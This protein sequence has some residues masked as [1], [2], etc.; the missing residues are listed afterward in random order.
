MD[1]AWCRDDMSPLHRLLLRNRADMRRIPLVAATGLLAAVSVITLVACS[2]P[3]FEN[4]DSGS[5]G[6]EAPWSRE[7]PPAPAR[8]LDGPLERFNAKYAA[9]EGVEGTGQ[10]MTSTGE[11]AITVYVSG[12]GDA[13]RIPDSF[14]GHPVLVRT[15]P[16]GFHATHSPAGED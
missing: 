10:G 6:S 15:V 1:P 9:T 5:P 16:G 13:A 8:T 7:P 2:V 3:P 11:D 4:P 12:G 14:E